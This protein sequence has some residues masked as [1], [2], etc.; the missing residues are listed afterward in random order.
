MALLPPRHH[1]PST[2]PGG[3]PAI[4]RAPPG[5]PLGVLT[6]SRDP[7]RTSP[8]LFGCPASHRLSPPGTRPQAR[9]GRGQALLQWTREQEW[10]DPRPSR[11]CMCLG[12]PPCTIRTTKC[13]GSPAGS[14]RRATAVP[15]R[16]ARPALYAPDHLIRPRPLEHSPLA[17]PPGNER[18]RGPSLPSP[19]AH[20]SSPHPESNNRLVNYHTS[21]ATSSPL[22]AW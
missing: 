16:R 21:P 13:A 1:P 14:A 4:A 12:S 2:A 9:R 20:H 19:I 22:V 15:V 3:L 7:A 17:P 6:R 10:H 5:H 8:E 11:E 18:L